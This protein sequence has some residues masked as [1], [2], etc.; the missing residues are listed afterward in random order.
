MV[1]SLLLGIYRF[2]RSQGPADKPPAPLDSRLLPSVIAASDERAAIG[3]WATTFFCTIISCNVLGLVPFNEA[4]TSGLGFSTGL[5]VSVWATAT[6][7]GL[8]KLGFTFPGHFIPGDQL[9]RGAAADAEGGTRLCV[10]GVRQE[11]GRED[12]GLRAGAEG[13]EERSSAAS[14]GQR[15]EWRHSR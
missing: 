10:E 9:L 11:A 2:W 12:R 3:I 8:Y 14:W 1:N 4:P 5:G 6:A 13:S 15:P 7:L